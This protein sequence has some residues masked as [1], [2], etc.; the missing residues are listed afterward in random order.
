MPGE[1]KEAVRATKAWAFVDETG[2]IHLNQLRAT[3][4]GAEATLESWQYQGR[5]YRI[6]PVEIRPLMES[7]D[8]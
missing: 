4:Q 1:R 3:R 6:I 2:K 7:D 8:K 5:R